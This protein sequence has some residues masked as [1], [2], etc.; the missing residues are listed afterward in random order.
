V[1]QHEIEQL[2]AQYRAGIEAELVLLQQL[3]DLAGRQK[4]STESRN[5]EQLALESDER[6]RVTRSLVTLEE[7]LG[8]VRSRLAEAKALAMTLPAYDTIVELRR[9]AA[10]LVARVLSVDQESLKSLA[11]AEM[12]RRAAMASLEKGETTLAGR[13]RRPARS[14]RLTPTRRPRGISAAAV[15]AS[16]ARTLPQGSRPGRHPET[17]RPPGVNPLRSYSARAGPLSP[18]TSRLTRAYPRAASRASTVR[19]RRAPLP[20]P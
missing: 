16:H 19:S 10:E 5:F 8:A 18:A 12:A 9:Q 14:P 17:N 1:T 2:L 20:C 11:D 13:T 7:S 4:T 6:D 3:S 15:S